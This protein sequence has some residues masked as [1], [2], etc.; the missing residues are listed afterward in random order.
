MKIED[1]LDGIRRIGRLPSDLDLEQFDEIVEYL[2]LLSHS[3]DQRCVPILLKVLHN[4]GDAGISGS[5]VSV[6][7]L[8]DSNVLEKKLS[9]SIREER[10]GDFYWLMMIALQ[11]PSEEVT[12]A[13]EEVVR[14]NIL[15]DEAQ[16]LAINYID[17][18]CDIK[19][20]RTEEIRDFDKHRL[21]ESR[22]EEAE[23]RLHLNQDL[24]LSRKS[25]SEK[26]YAKVVRLLK[27]YEDLLSAVDLKKFMYSKTQSSHK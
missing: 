20:F 14:Q 26:K 22:I 27:D 13:I 9:G 16:A 1:V 6:L 25:F 3:P 7:G 4:N 24:V 5:I 10:D 23:R 8:Q 15:D 21:A 11:N 17:E 12:G 18:N 2:S 19:E